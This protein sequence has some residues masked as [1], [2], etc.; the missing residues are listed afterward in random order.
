M[1]QNYHSIFIQAS[2][3]VVFPQLVLWGESSWW[4]SKSNMRVKRIKGEEITVGA[5]LRYEISPPW[6][7]AWEV[8]ITEIKDQRFIKRT[9]L[10]G[11]FC[12]GEQISVR[13]Q[14][15]G[16]LVEFHMEYEVPKRI[17]RFFW[18]LIAEKLHDKN[19]Q[20]ILKTLKTFLE[21]AKAS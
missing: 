5:L 17:D 16:S 7:P 20:L 13:P 12:G 10:N 3:A 4:P 2:P 21:N 15:D 6:G 1:R 11:M 19:I 14:K 18:R 9:F 8:E